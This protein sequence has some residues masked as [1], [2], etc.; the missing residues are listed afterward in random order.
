MRL[1][2][3][4]QHSN[5]CYL[6]EPDGSVVGSDSDGGVTGGGIESR[7]VDGLVNAAAT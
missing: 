1:I 4:L 5:Q 2:A 7:T 3:Y 6:R